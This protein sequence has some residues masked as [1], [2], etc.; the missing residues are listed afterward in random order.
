ML[1]QALWA[2]GIAAAIGALIVLGMTMMM[3]GP[4]HEAAE[5][6]TE[7][8]TGSPRAAPTSTCTTPTAMTRSARSPGPSPC[9]RTTHR[10]PQ[11]RARARHR[12]SAGGRTAQGRAN[13]FVDDFRGRIG[14]IIEQVLNSS[15]VSR[16]RQAA[17]ITAHSTAE[18]SGRSAEASRRLP[19]MSARGGR[20]QRNC[21]SRSSRSAAGFR[22]RTGSRP[23]RSCSQRTDQRMTELTRRR[24]HRRRGQADHLDRGTDQSA[25][26]N[27]TIEAARAG[28][29]GRGFAVVAQEVKTLAARPRSDRRDLGA[30]RQHAARHRGVGQRHQ[31]DRH[32]I[33]R[34][35]GISTSISSAVEQQGTAT[36]SIAQACSRR[37][38][39]PRRR[40][41]HRAGRQGRGR[42]RIHLGPDAEIGAG[43]RRGLHASEAE[44]EKFLDSVRAA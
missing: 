10:A 30:H 26:L 6:V 16:G 41:Q 2:M 43:A 32:T 11:A 37:R 35:S 18:M 12:R 19:N 27:A 34:I 24:P 42:N 9:S 29:A 17:S 25:A 3:V 44:V 40:R 31:G 1:A 7:S 23:T 20:L 8:L 36:K 21:R 38:R 15:G 33:E 13:S 39:H 22:S 28:D 5:A 14:G 4:R